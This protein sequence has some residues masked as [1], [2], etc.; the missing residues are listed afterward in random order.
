M[1]SEAT[2]GESLLRIS[3]IVRRLQLSRNQV[4][5]I[6]RTGELPSVRFGTAIRFVPE[7]VERYIQAHRKRRK[8]A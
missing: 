1:S 2:A 5:K 4:Y 8:P 7:D 3:D 6:T